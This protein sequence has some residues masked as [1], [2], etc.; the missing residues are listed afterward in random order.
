MDRR[1]DGQDEIHQDLDIKHDIPCFI[2]HICGG[3]EIDREQNRGEDIDDEQDDFG[4]EEEV[5]DVKEDAPEPFVALKVLDDVARPRQD[6]E[7]HGDEID[8]GVDIK[9]DAEL[10]GVKDA[11]KDVQNEI[12]GD[13]YDEHAIS[14][15]RG[16]IDRRF[17]AENIHVDERVDDQADDAEEII[18]HIVYLILMAACVFSIGNLGNF[19]LGAACNSRLSVTRIRN[20]DRFVA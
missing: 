5:S 14:L 12:D 11:P 15:D 2:R 3:I 6:G 17:L 10:C 16:Q 9:G 13:R 8:R 19:R 4:Q 20:N 18:A 7:A 1:V